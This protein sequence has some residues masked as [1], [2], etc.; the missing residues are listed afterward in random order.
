[1][2]P[3][4]LK[5]ARKSVGMSQEKLSRL[6][7]IKGVNPRSRLSSYEQGRSEPPFE[8]MVKMAKVLGVPEYYFYTIDDAVA[9]EMLGLNCYRMDPQSNPYYYLMSD[10]RKLREQRDEAIRLLGLV[11]DC[12]KG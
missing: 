7:G 12:L 2:V 4:R 11:N 6:V 10:N 5:E 8:L 3:K 9:R 1:M